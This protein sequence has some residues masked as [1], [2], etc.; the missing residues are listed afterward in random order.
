LYIQVTRDT[1]IKQWS[2]IEPG[3]DAVISR[4]FGSGYSSGQFSIG[5]N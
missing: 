2:F 1:I 4:E 3:A 5:I